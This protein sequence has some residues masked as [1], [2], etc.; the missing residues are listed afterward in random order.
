MS[1]TI[2]KPKPAHSMI[3]ESLLAENDLQY[4]LFL[5]VGYD[6]FAICVVEVNGKYSVAL[7]QYHFQKVNTAAALAGVSPG[8]AGAVD[9]GLGCASCRSRLGCVPLGGGGL[10]AAGVEARMP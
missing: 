1:L 3:D 10:V 7:E 9:P 4:D 5:E 6:Q 2:T 8:A